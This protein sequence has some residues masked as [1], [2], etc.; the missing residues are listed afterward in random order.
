MH[1]KIMV[2]INTSCIHCKPWPLVLCTVSV[3]SSIVHPRILL[4]LALYHFFNKNP[5]SRKLETSFFY[6]C[7]ILHHYRSN[8]ILSPLFFAIYALRFKRRSLLFAA[9]NSLRRKYFFFLKKI[10]YCFKRFI[11]ATPIFIVLHTLKEQ[12]FASM[13]D[14]VKVR[15]EQ[16][17]GHHVQAG[18]HPKEM[19]IY[20]DLHG[21]NAG[22]HWG[23]GNRTV[24][25]EVNHYSG[26]IV[27]Q[28]QNKRK[29]NAP[30]A[31][32]WSDVAASGID[33]AN[34]APLIENG[35]QP[36]TVVPDVIP[37]QQTSHYQTSTHHQQNFYSVYPNSSYM[38]KS[39][40]AP[41]SVQWEMLHFAQK[42]AMQSMQY[43]VDPMSYFNHMY[44]QNAYN[45]NL[46]SLQLRYLMQGSIIA[47]SPLLLLAQYPHLVGV[48][49]EGALP[50]LSTL[51]ASQEAG[52]GVASPT[53]ETHPA[54]FF[55][56]KS[57]NDNEIHKGIKYCHWSCKKTLND[58]IDSAFKEMSGKGGSV[59]IFVC[60]SSRRL[61]AVGEV[62]SAADYSIVDP[63]YDPPPIQKG[64][65]PTQSPG[66]ATRKGGR[67]HGLFGV[68]WHHIKYV[69]QRA[70][71]ALKPLVA[72]LFE[73]AADAAHPSNGE[74]ETAYELG[75]S[76]TKVKGTTSSV[77]DDAEKT[78][79]R[80]ST[81]RSF[82]ALSN[83]QDL[84]YDLGIKVL[85][86]VD[87]FAGPMTLLSLFRQ[88]DIEEMEGKQPESE[89]SRDGRYK[90]SDRSSGRGRSS[91]RGSGRLVGGNR[92]TRRSANP[93]G[94]SAGN[95]LDADEITQSVDQGMR[96]RDS[97]RAFR[98]KSLRGGRGA[99]RGGSRGARSSGRGGGRVGDRGDGRG[100][101]R[102]GDK[103][104]P[105]Q[106]TVEGSDGA[107]VRLVQAYA[108]EPQHRVKQ[109]KGKK[110]K[111]TGCEVTS[112]NIGESENVAPVA[113]TKNDSMQ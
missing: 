24:P 61:A 54:R 30:A 85:D 69:P 47:Y 31:R 7:R 68:R 93:G 84:G 112:Q 75:D 42:V 63:R 107:R 81:P 103:S 94:H 39:R 73:D 96:L 53:M 43:G 3:L 95:R 28:Q 9:T 18:G 27:Q 34:E 10:K 102:S 82:L 16:I 36:A 13:S 99:G 22:H 67:W 86:L 60:G 110:T 8:C 55:I 90:K 46:N 48:N 87:K 50:L 5:Y 52:S 64:A 37:N 106:R 97:K 45:F 41:L 19:Q 105:R 71:E 17:Q 66:F 111:E 78:L 38:G 77:N 29:Q 92:S 35:Q 91:Y 40:S 32:A 74:R 65:P 14:G 109:K 6:Y 15:T 26:S 70:F 113:T 100:G 23:A 4:F 98:G 62:L 25:T 72:R 101:D 76:M 89:R 21:Q 11:L 12:I 44:M 20:G 88:F 1:T 83:G 56:V 57:H 108:F 33:A 58:K 2:T 79:R 80:R 49:M 59:Y 51:N 104:R